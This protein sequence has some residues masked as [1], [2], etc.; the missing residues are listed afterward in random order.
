MPPS[1][2]P[3]LLPPPDNS[4]QPPSP[5]NANY[6][7][8]Y[9]DRRPEFGNAWPARDTQPSIQYDRND[10]HTDYARQRN[11]QQVYGHST[12]MVPQNYSPPRPYPNNVHNTIFAPNSRPAPYTTTRPPQRYRRPSITQG[13]KDLPPFHYNASHPN[14]E[15]FPDPHAMGDM[16]HTASRIERPNGNDWR[17]EQYQPPPPEVSAPSFYSN[18]MGLGYQG[19]NEGYRG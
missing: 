6:D 15:M 17:E 2:Q 4:A 11:E 19:T 14:R 18:N 1:L 16:R 8:G 13:L 5:V 12:A 10:Y 3:S 7:R 9:V